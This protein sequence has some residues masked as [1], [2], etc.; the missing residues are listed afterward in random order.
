M[1][2]GTLKF[3]QME[4]NEISIK[5][6]YYVKE[7]FS[8]PE[9]DQSEQTDRSHDTQA[10]NYSDKAKMFYMSSEENSAAASPTDVPIAIPQLPSSRKHSRASST[11][12]TNG[13][14]GFPKDMEMSD[15]SSDRSRSNSKAD[16]SEYYGLQS[17]E[18]RSRSNSRFSASGHYGSDSERN[19]SRSNSKLLGSG[20][21]SM[22][23]EDTRSR[24]NSKYSASDH[25]GLESVEACIRNS[26]SL[27]ASPN[28]LYN[29]NFDN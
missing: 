12:L 1:L 22:G 17:E 24:S 13:E 5:D 23:S 29:R 9:S 11:D 6:N 21:Y 18:N 2:K 16:A 4:D 27:E 19:R 25:Y 26:E 3:S 8:S 7:V 28:P 20:H 10:K 14:N 15:Y